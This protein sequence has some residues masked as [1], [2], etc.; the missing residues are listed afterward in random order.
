MRTQILLVVLS[1]G[2][3]GCLFESGKDREIASL[4]RQLASTQGQLSATILTLETARTTIR[5]QSVEITK[6]IEVMNV[7]GKVLQQ[8]A[9]QRDEAV[10]LVT[11]MSNEM[12]DSTK[13]VKECGDTLKQMTSVM[14][15][16]SAIQ[17]FDSVPSRLPL[18]QSEPFVYQQEP[19]R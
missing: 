10:M 2:L 7:Q 15:V 4:K 5:E 17:S 6:N 9:A 12:R 11:R 19:Q 3:S 8:T 14:K 16:M 18:P 1:L 13:L